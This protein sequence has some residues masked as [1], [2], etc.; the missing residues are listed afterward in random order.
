MV[1][2]FDSRIKELQ[3]KKSN[4]DKSVLE[5]QRQE[6]QKRIDEILSNPVAE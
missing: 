6:Y 3:E 2:T 5:S 4:L 1:I